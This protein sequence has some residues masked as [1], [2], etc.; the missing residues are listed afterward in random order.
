[1]TSLRKIPPI[2]FL[3]SLTW[4]ALCDLPAQESNPTLSAP[5]QKETV[6]HEI[7][8]NSTVVATAP[9]VDLIDPIV[10]ASAYGD[11]TVW[12][13]SGKEPLPWT[14]FKPNDFSSVPVSEDATG[15]RSLG[16]VPAPG[17]HPRLFFSAEDLPAI[18]KRLKETRAG[19][20]AW[21]NVLAYCN[22]FKL[23][24]DENA[25]YAKPD[26]I[27][28]KFS[29]HGRVPLSRTGGYDSK[30]EDFYSILT[31]G[32]RPEKEN[33]FF[34]LA[35][36]ESLR[37]LIEEDAAAAKTLA[38]GVVTAVKLEQ[39]R[40]QAKDKP[41][42]PGQ[43]PNP[44]TSRLNAICL[45]MT[46]DFLFNWMTQEQR[47]IVHDELVT[48]S[49][50]QDNYGTFNNAE[51]ARSNW[52]TFSYWVFDL[53]AIEGEPGFNDLKF[54]GLYRGWRNFMTSSYF[55]SGAVYEGEGKSLLGMDAVVAFDRL[56][57]KYNLRPLS[58]HPTPR[59]HY[60][61][62]LTASIL[63]TLDKWVV[64]D[65][66]GGID[67]GIGT[68]IDVVVAHYL[69]PEDK[70][71]DLLYRSMV[72]DDYSRLPNRCDWT[73]NMVVL[74]ALFATDYDPANTP[75]SIELPNT[76]FCGQRAMMMT[77]SSWDKDATFLTMHVRGV[78]G[79]HP[80]RDRN[81]IMLFGKGRP[82]V[83]IPYNG[84]QEAGWKCNTALIHGK[85]QSNTTPGRV[86]DFIDQPLASF[87]VGDAKYCWD[88]VWRTT[89][90][91]KDGKKATSEDV[92]NGNLDPGASWTPVEQSF[93]DFAFSKI[94][95][96]ALDMPLKF[97]PHW[98]E[99]SGIV[100]AYIKQINTPVLKAFRTAGLLR[101]TH[102][103]VL[104]VDDIQQNCLPTRYDWNLTLYNDVV[105]VKIP[106]AGT[107]PGEI[108]LAGTNS[109]TADGSV[110]TGEPALLVRL[111]D[112]KGTPSVN[113]GMINDKGLPALPSDKGTINLLTL[114]TTS[115]SPDFKV[116]LYPFRIGEALPISCWNEVHNQLAVVFPNQRDLIDL[117]PSSW[118]K[119]DIKITRNGNEIVKLNN[120]IPQLHDPSSDRITRE[121]KELPQKLIGIKS[122]NPDGLPGLVASWPLNVIRDGGLPASQSGLPAIP[123]TNAG[124][125]SS[126]RIAVA[127]FPKE[128]VIVPLNLKEKITDAFT[129]SFWIKSDPN[130]NGSLIDIASLDMFSL[131]FAQDSMLRLNAQGKWFF[132]ASINAAMVCNW[133][134]FAITCDGKNM[135]LYRNG[136]PLMTQTVDR[137][138]NPSE[139]F[140]MG[141][142][143]QGLYSDLRIYSAAL[144]PDQVEKIYL[145][146]VS[147]EFQ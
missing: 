97:S 91:T 137:K 75:Q 42:K 18:R 16:E 71:I 107:L 11:K 39:E 84:G 80:Y 125:E 103:Y 68:P 17:I 110:K 26:W 50:W 12:S 85:D 58:Q 48:L 67:K 53:L 79:G 52:A 147:N 102:P 3:I 25:D 81:G 74:C 86:I 116:M 114:S 21:K 38:I 6:S 134:Q 37:C 61:N 56:S 32:G 45:G 83:T 88:W 131:D 120:P 99:P 115:V 98:V 143:F 63:P 41:V 20:E 119:T 127:R 146:R 9:A 1:M 70:K 14:L 123:A 46:Y 109:L 62:F 76:F 2:V 112:G 78:S 5:F 92:V 77:R 28:G 35:S 126:S 30:R 140:K 51:S 55:K 144:K 87:M 132:E 7:S 142:G 95:S 122:F 100:S 10:R 128:G 90:S 40:R 113:I 69:Y 44:S 145:K 59:N 138:I 43:P 118:G 33:S 111:V 8:T 89:T 135:M 34:P 47:N 136:Y 105:R 94:K 104:V 66:L 139:S 106:P 101:G 19:Q 96:A 93:N 72:G 23:T 27:N 64:F 130:P 15:V 29:I 24:Y 60:G 129:V 36:V 54:R 133:T 117:T 108:I 141:A 4:G 73:W 31:S 57:K 65:I 13:Y 124:I 121:V 22:A 82:W 49:A